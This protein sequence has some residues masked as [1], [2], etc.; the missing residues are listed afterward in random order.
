MVSATTLS[1]SIDQLR[2]NVRIHRRRFVSA[3]GLI[4]LLDEAS[5]EAN[6]YMSWKSDDLPPALHL[7]SDAEYVTSRLRASDGGGYG[8]LLPILAAWC[9]L[10][11]LTR[12]FSG[13]GE[14]DLIRFWQ[15]SVPLGIEGLPLVLIAT[16][17]V[18]LV[19]AG[20]RSAH[21]R[22]VDSSFADDSEDVALGIR[23]LQRSSPL[24]K[25]GDATA[26]LER[27]A[28]E[29]ARAADSWRG[30]NNQAD[31][32]RQA[33]EG[34]LRVAQGVATAGT[35]LTEAAERFGS[36]SSELVPA[37][38][39]LKDQLTEL[40]SLGT[41]A[42]EQLTRSDGTMAAM[43]R[44]GTQTREVL[45]DLV[46]SAQA[47]STQMAGIKVSA[48][49][50]EKLGSTMD[51]ALRKSQMSLG[52]IEPACTSLSEASQVM[53]KA[54]GRLESVLTMLD[55]PDYRAEPR[56]VQM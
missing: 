44:D 49:Q 42:F 21:L 46:R 53:A 32:A 15:D 9:Y 18:V 43:I 37:L 51:D 3:N 4:A 29:L 20:A 5:I 35:K 41:R 47:L 13:S 24:S 10:L 16:F 19:Q 55:D 50:M 1:N 34:M 38:D 23:A 7:L 52:K 17:V 2:A 33:M 27:A 14:G 12:A 8:F 40:D 6:D 30:F 26:D 54:T 56:G 22:R 45:T 25:S 11:M 28:K 31:T 48:Q 39:R 36:T